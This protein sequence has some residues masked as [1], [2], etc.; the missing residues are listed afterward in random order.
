MALRI[1]T[2]DNIR[3]GNTLYKAL[4]HPNAA[5]RGRGLVKALTCNSPVAVYDPGGAAG[6]FNEIFS[7]DGIE[8]A[9]IYVQQVVRIGETVL[10]HTAK[11]VTEIT[12]SGAR[13]VFVVAFD[14]GRM[15]AQLQPYLPDSVEA[16]SLDSLRIPPERL[17]NR[18]A[19]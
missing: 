11:P 4:T 14:A 6:P 16:L 5:R 2:F 15:I 1:E 9:G 7:L 13:S 17:T 19:Y 8:I 18:N 10:G 3:G 12:D